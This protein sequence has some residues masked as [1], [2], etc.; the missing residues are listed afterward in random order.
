MTDRGSW[1]E[2]RRRFSCTRL[3]L[4]VNKPVRGLRPD[5][6]KPARRGSHYLVNSLI[7]SFISLAVSSADSSLLLISACNL[8]S[9]II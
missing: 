5:F 6:R 8:D 2:R 7:S 9:G 4:P 3:H 1:W